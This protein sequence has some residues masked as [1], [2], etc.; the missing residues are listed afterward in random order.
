[1]KA[2]IQS[3]TVVIVNWNSG[4]LLRRCLAHLAAQTR[5]A[6][7]IIV[8]DNGST[9]DSLAGIA[10]AAANIA[11][12]RQDNRGFAQANN[13]AAAMAV[14]CEWIATLNPDAFPAPDWLERLL[15]AASENPDYSCFAS[16]L[17]DDANPGIVDGA[18]DAMHVSGMHWRA[19]HG[20]AVSND[21]RR[22]RQV[23]SPCAA[24]ALYRREAFLAAGGFDER[25]F[26]YAEDVDL[27]FRLRLAGH[28]C[29]YVPAAVVRHVGSATSGGRHSDFSVYHGHRNLVWLYVK[30][31]PSALFWLYLPQ[32]LMANLAAIVRFT[33]RGQ[34]RVILRAKWHAI[35]EL[36]RVWRQWRGIQATR[37]AGA[38]EIRR[39]MEKGFLMPYFRALRDRR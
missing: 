10:E 26:C 8:V 17:L 6:D 23:F 20:A 19:G 2:A 34:G 13:L 16:L 15:R 12:V 4:P 14:D 5:P 24:A 21:T 25:F 37:K 9:D 7:R 11:V 28:R 31:M 30:N 32:H 35:R 27:G 18:G 3:V 36:P 38:R 29:L 1:V 33:L 22:S 39:A